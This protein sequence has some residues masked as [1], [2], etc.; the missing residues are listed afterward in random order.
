MNKISANII[1]LWWLLIFAKSN[2]YLSWK[3]LLPFT[4][5]TLDKAINILITNLRYMYWCVSVYFWIGDNYLQRKDTYVNYIYTCM[6]NNQVLE[7]NIK[8]SFKAYRTCRI[9]NIVFFIWF[10][11]CIPTQYL[12]KCTSRDGRSFLY[13]L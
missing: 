7:I 12:L 11:F 6:N 5:T 3:L 2:M 10:S 9:I 1:C 4:M 13:Y 8:I